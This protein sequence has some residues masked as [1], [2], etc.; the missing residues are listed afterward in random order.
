MNTKCEITYIPYSPR[1]ILQMISVHF[2]TS[3]TESHESTL[4]LVDDRKI[5]LPSFPTQICPP[6]LS[7]N[8][9]GNYN[10]RQQKKKSLKEISEG[11]WMK[12]EKKICQQKEINGLQ[13]SFSFSP[14]F[15]VLMWFLCKHKTSIFRGEIDKRQTGFKAFAKY[16][17]RANTLKK[18]RWH[19]VN[20]GTMFRLVHKSW[21][22]VGA[23]KTPLDV[24]RTIVC[25]VMRRRCKSNL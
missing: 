14:H 20:S 11:K 22:R 7:Q 23:I 8:I 9:D 3:I 4:T 13:F 19:K 15:Y 17:D 10:F 12:E 16:L 24:R 5:S 6:E 2:A 21:Q 18:S 25:L 1:I